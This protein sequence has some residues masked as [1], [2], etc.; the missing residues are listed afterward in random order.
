MTDPLNETHDPA[1]KSWV[2]IANVADCDFPIQNLPFGVFRPAPGQA[3]RV[4]VAI[5][6]QI[7][8]VA[9]AGAAFDGLAAE[10]AKSCSTGTLNPLMSLGPQTWPA[11][12]LAL[13]RALSTQDG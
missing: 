6:D 2:D 12:R 4:G 9:A 3:P 1:R 7:V 10:A 8:D 5:G 11:L 13:S